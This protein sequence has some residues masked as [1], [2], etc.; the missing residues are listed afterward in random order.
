MNLFSCC[1]YIKLHLH[2]KSNLVCTKSQLAPIKTIFPPKL[3]LCGA[4]LLAQL[5]QKVKAFLKLNIEDTLFWTDSTKV[6]A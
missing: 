1:R 2:T 5:M 3:G 4:V 6:L